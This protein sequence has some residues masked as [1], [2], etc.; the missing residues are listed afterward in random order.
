MENLLASILAEY[1]VS[2]SSWRICVEFNG[3][4]AYRGEPIL[5]LRGAGYVTR[6]VSYTVY[7][8]TWKNVSQTKIRENRNL[9]IG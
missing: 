4:H 2:Y 1:G 7:W 9:Q 8:P 5:R 3:L 6:S